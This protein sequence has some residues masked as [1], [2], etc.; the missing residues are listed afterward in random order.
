MNTFGELKDMM[1]KQLL[2]N[3]TGV[4]NYGISRT[5]VKGDKIITTPIKKSDF[6]KKENLNYDRNTSIY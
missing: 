3:G 1:A 2:N 6:Y 5:E 4:I